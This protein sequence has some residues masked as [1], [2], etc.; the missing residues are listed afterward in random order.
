MYSATLLNLED[1]ADRKT[2]RDVAGL[3][4][5]Q[6]RER[7][8]DLRRMEK[9]LAHA[10]REMRAALGRAALPDHRSQD[11]IFV[12]GLSGCCRQGA[13]SIVRFRPRGRH[14]SCFAAGRSRDER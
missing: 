5:V 4:L 3:R 14:R 11:Y 7:I 9:A 13:H 12:I 8:A 6:I 1:C 2:I 10:L